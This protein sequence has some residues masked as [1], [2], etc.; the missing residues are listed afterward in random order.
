MINTFYLRGT[1]PSLTVDLSEI[2][3]AL[4]T[5]W[6]ARLRAFCPPT[7]VLTGVRS[8]AQDNANAPS[9]STFATTNNSGLRSG[10]ALPLNSACVI[11]HITAQRGRSFRGRTYWYGLTTNDLSN[12]ELWGA[13]QV[14]SLV[15]AWNNFIAD[16]LVDVTSQTYTNVIVSKYTNNAPRASGL[17]TQVTGHSADTAIDSMRTR[18]EGRGS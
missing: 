10:T 16:I 1:E 3:D 18:L 2:N 6:I 17:A 8:T 7:V 14:A 15:T 11:K 9:V 5:A 4:I 13:T 12:A